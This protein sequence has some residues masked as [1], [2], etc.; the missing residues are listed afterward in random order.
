MV[1]L[2][3]SRIIRIFLHDQAA[4]FSSDV[5]SY[6]LDGNM[7]CRQ[8]HLHDISEGDIVKSDNGNLVWNLDMIIS[9]RPVQT[10]GH[11]IIL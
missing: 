7:D 10:K 11:L 3:L 2:Y 8:R 5:L 6:L 1:D 4:D 9:C